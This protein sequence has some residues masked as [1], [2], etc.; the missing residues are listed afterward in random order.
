LTE[1]QTNV[2][3]APRQGDEMRLRK[4]EVKRVMFAAA[5][6]TLFF[7]AVK[8]EASPPADKEPVEGEVLLKEISSPTHSQVEEL[9][10]LVAKSSHEKSQQ[11]FAT[12]YAARFIGRKTASGPRYDPEKMTAAHLTLPFGTVV[13]VLNPA[14]NLDVHVTINDRCAPKPY[15]L[16]DLSRAAAKKIGLWG[17]GRIKV[18]IIPLTDPPK[19]KA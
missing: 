18:V 19:K 12:Y 6:A 5:F 15:Q 11:G 8:A 7:L 17:K 3:F 13:R 10:K 2:Y 4:S 9:E 1:K 16:I 14:N